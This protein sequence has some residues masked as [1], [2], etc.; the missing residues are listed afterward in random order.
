MLWPKQRPE[1][2]VPVLMQNIGRVTQT[3]IYRRLITYQTHSRAA[4]QGYAFFK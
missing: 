3:M 4:K 1:I 2:H